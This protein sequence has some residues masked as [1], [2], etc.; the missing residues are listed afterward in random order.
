MTTYTNCFTFSVTDVSFTRN[1]SYIQLS[2]N[3]SEWHFGQMGSLWFRTKHPSGLLMY[4]GWRPGSQN[5]EYLM[6][7]ISSGKLNFTGDLGSGTLFFGSFSWK[8][9]YIQYAL[10]LSWVSLFQNDFLLKCQNLVFFQFFY[11]LHCFR[12][13]YSISLRFYLKCSFFVCLVS[14]SL[15]FVNF[16]FAFLFFLFFH[17]FISILFLLTSMAYKTFFI[18]SCWKFTECPA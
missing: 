3:T 9:R 4:A 7:T 8:E 15:V 6:I 14:F 18:V 2:L 16:L 5:T 12:R 17:S 10:D 13:F 1:N 11:F